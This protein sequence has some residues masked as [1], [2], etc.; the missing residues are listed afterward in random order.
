M[1]V[2]SELTELSR[3]ASAR[4]QYNYAP[5]PTEQFLSICWINRMM[6]T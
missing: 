4:A 3:N 1:L 2:A 5:W 6:A